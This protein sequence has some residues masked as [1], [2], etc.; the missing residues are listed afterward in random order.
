V[1]GI[2]LGSA[3]FSSYFRSG[4]GGGVSSSPFS[5]PGTTRVWARSFAYKI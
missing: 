2:G 3:S 1:S 5:C 4:R